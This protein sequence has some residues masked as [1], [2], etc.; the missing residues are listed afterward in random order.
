MYINSFMNF[1]SFVNGF[2]FMSND[3]LAAFLSANAYSFTLEQFIYI[4][5]YFKNEKKRRKQQ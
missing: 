3:E 4:R 2:T 5:D 1:D